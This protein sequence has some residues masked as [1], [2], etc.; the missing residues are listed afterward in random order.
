MS[1]EGFVEHD[2]DYLLD[3]Q[4]LVAGPGLAS[5]NHAALAI[6]RTDA[7]IRPESK[8]RAALPDAPTAIPDLPASSQA[9]MIVRLRSSR[10]QLE[11]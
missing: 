3:H 1:L 2:L 5:Q 7:S 4:Q 9:P 8:N 10:S 6:D 11:S